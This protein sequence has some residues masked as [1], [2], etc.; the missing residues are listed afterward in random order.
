MRI[1]HTALAD[2]TLCSL[3]EEFVTREGTDYGDRIYSL[4]DKVAQVRRQ[5]DQGSVVI[6]YDPH[7][8]SAHIMPSDAVPD[9]HDDA[10]DRSFAAGADSSD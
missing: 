10:A 6:V 8:E 1:P 3:I 2:A 4:A 9:D 5:L 7:T